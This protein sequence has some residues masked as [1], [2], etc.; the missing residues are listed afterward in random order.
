MSQERAQ[1]FIRR[2]GTEKGFLRLLDNLKSKDDLLKAA[3]AF[4]YDFTTEELTLAIVRTMDLQE[5][6]LESVTGGAVAFGYGRMLSIA[7][8]LEL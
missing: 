1:E 5:G 6:D 7:S 4:G 3:R 2:V 8:L